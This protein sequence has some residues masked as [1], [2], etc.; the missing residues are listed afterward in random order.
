MNFTRDTKSEGKI[1][2]GTFGAINAA[3]ET[4]T[5]LPFELNR[6]GRVKHSC[7]EKKTLYC[8]ACYCLNLNCER[9]KNIYTK[10]FHEIYKTVLELWP[11][12][13]DM[14]FWYKCALDHSHPVTQGKCLE[15]Q[16]ELCMSGI[17]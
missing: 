1:S 11:C 4:L 5:E 7:T 6:N 10:R 16:C 12:C 3:G 17:E 9:Q 13:C 2:Y 15:P 8:V 14:S